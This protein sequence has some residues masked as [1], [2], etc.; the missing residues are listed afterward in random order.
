MTRYRDIRYDRHLGFLT[1]PFVP[2]VVFLGAF[3]L[4]GVYKVTGS[5]HALYLCYTQCC[6]RLGTGLETPWAGSGLRTH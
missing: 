6:N 5:K 3:G 4:F 1:L 2:W